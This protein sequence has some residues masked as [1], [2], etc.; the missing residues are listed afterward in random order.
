MPVREALTTPSTA[1]ATKPRR[2]GD[3]V[4]Y[5]SRWGTSTHSSYGGAE[6]VLTGAA[7]PLRVKGSWTATVA[8]V[9]A[10]GSNTSIPAGSL[11]LS[12]QGPDATKLGAL[13]TGATVT[14][15]T[16]ISAGWENTVEAVG[17]R[18]WLVEDGHE[19]V[20]PVS[21]LTAQTH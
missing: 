16:T 14:I 18:E 4:L 12:A 17:G 19:S 20:R 8:R 2:D 21:T 13:V 6:V 1:G 11:V 3:L 5:T 10:I 7:L 9:G 15:A